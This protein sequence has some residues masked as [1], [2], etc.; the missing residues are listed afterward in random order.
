MRNVPKTFYKGFL[1]KPK[2][3]KHI[4]LKWFRHTFGE[5]KWKITQYI[6]T[7]SRKLTSWRRS[8]DITLQTLFQDVLRTSAG[9]FLQTVR[10]YNS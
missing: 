5:I 2:T 8:K 4:T 6:C 1:Q 7:R 10:I 9:R 3:I